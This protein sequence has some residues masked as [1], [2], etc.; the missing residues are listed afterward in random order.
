MQAANPG[1]FQNWTKFPQWV[2]PWWKCLV[3]PLCTDGRVGT[4][5]RRGPGLPWWAAGP[6]A[7]GAVPCLPVDGLCKTKGF[8]EIEF[9]SQNFVWC[10]SSP[11]RLSSLHITK[12]QTKVQKKYF[13]STLRETVLPAPR[14]KISI[15]NIFHCHIPK[16]ACQ[17]RDQRFPSLSPVKVVVFIYGFWLAFLLRECPGYWNSFT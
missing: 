5:A 1:H 3:A 12:K 11:G 4:W 7:S 14:P 16:L 17:H 2:S 8:L 10:F 15:N 6:T 13:I 9:C